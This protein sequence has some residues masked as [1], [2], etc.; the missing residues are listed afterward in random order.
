LETNPTKDNP[1]QLTT[2]MQAA[3]NKI[4]IFR[5]T[6][7]ASLATRVQSVWTLL[8]SESCDSRMHISS[9]QRQAGQGRSGLGRAFEDVSSLPS[10]VSRR[11]KVG[12]CGMLFEC[13]PVREI[14]REC[15]SSKS[16]VE[17]M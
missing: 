13:L 7:G 14:K 17:T 2:G 12:R 3:H 11:R 15:N 9:V 5:D 6:T 8:R 16:E 10:L 4:M 1:P